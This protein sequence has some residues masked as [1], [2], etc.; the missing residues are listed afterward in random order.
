[1]SAPYEV[2]VFDGKAPERLGTAPDKGGA[3]SLWRNS[4]HAVIAKAGE[5]LEPKPSCALKQQTALRVAVLSA[6]LAA[7]GAPPEPLPVPGTKAPSSKPARGGRPKAA[8]ADEADED[9]LEDDGAEEDEDDSNDPDDPPEVDLEAALAEGTDEPDRGPGDLEGPDL[10]EPLRITSAPQESRAIAPEPAPLRNTPPA[11]SPEASSD[12]QTP[13]AVVA[14]LRAAP[15]LSPTRGWVKTNAPCE[16][17]EKR[18][19]Y[20]YR[21]ELPEAF[22]GLCYNDRCRARKWAAA[23]PGR[24]PEQ[25]RDL[26]VTT[27]RAS[28]AARTARRDAARERA[29][30]AKG[31]RPRGRPPT[32]AWTNLRR[33]VEQ[34][35]KIGGRLGGLEGLRRLEAARSV[36]PVDGLAAYAAAQMARM[37]ATNCIELHARVGERPMLVTAQWLDG[38]SALTL[39]GEALAERDAAVAALTAAQ[40]ASVRVQRLVERAG[41]VERLEAIFAWS[42]GLMKLG[43]G[44]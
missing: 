18:P 24:T 42:E 23:E 21:P 3:K 19:A 2:W 29:V 32:P 10:D 13:A 12:T 36:G 33:E 9:E 25:A 17:C 4:R 15:P 7:G 8:P 30:G 34:L 40:A 22:R 44:Q 11:P 43:G 31:G 1:M 14:L 39:R 35:L 41:G 5:V 20:R 26:V 27:V 28:T 6:W 37:K 16:A 38:K